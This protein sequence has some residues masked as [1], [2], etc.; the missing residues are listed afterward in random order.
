MVDWL[1]GFLGSS[2]VARLF[3]VIAVGYVA[4]EVTFPGKFRFGIAAVLFIGMG[5]GAWDPAFTVPESLTTLGLAVF[6]YCVG[7]ETAAGFFRTMRNQGAATILCTVVGLLAGTF[8]AWLCIH[9]MQ[10]PRE[11]IVG[12]YCGALN[13][14]PALATVAEALHRRGASPQEVALTVVGCGLAYPI[15]VLTLLLKIQFL[16]SRKTAAASPPEAAAGTKWIPPVILIVESLN[17][18]KEGEGAWTCGAVQR[19]TGVVLSRIRRPDGKWTL[20]GEGD[21][22]T[23]GSEVVAIGGEEQ[24]EAAARLLGRRSAESVDYTGVESHRYFLSN[25]RL[26]GRTLGSLQLGNIGAVVTRIRRGDVNIPVREGTV[27]QLGDRLRVVSYRDTEGAVRKLLGNSLQVLGETGYLTF[28]I[29]IFLG[30]ILGSIPIPIPGLETPLRLGAAG[31]PLVMALL[32]GALG[33]TGSFVWNLPYSSNQTLKLFG[34]LLF[35]AALGLQ[36]GGHVLPALESDGWFIAGLAVCIGLATHLSFWVMLR[37]FGIRNPAVVSGQSAA[38]QT[39]PAALAFAC[40]KAGSN[41]EVTTAY[42]TIFP[43]AMIGKILLAQ[44]LLLL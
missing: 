36:A 29:G 17:K 43:F 1:H 30:L 33:R 7:L 32:L 22:L 4:G 5:I 40:K 10:K 41:L 25:P 12:V 19:E 16:F 27:L 14:A 18:E 28:A 35:L 24:V 13:N 3:L 20:L 39:M 38:L 44:L 21:E 34:L 37:L 23:A 6:V 8:V 26:A 15:T 9:F 42:A 2:V 11:L 31:G